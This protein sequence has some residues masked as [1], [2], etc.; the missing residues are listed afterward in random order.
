MVIIIMEG[1]IR[2]FS[3]HLMWI[4]EGKITDYEEMTVFNFHALQQ[5]N[6]MCYNNAM[7]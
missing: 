4:T 2:H 1:R 3:I 5:Q 7:I 6:K